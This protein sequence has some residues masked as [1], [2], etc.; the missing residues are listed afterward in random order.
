M[1]DTQQAGEQRYTLRARDTAVVLG[2]DRQRH[3]LVSLTAPGLERN[4]VREPYF[5]LNLYRI[6]HGGRL[7]AIA[8]YEPF[9]LVYATESGLKLAWQPTEANPCRLEAEYT[10]VDE[11]TVDLKLFLEA[12][13]PL[14]NYELTVSSYFDF[15][16]EPY[17]VVPSWP[18]KTAEDDLLLL[19][20]EDHPYIKGHYVYL[21]RDNSAA[22]TL[23][24][25]RW[26]D[27]KSGRPIAHFVTGPCYGV[28][29]AVMGTESLHIVQAA[30]PD[31]CR[32]IGI[33][34]SSPDESDII[35]QHNALYFTLFGGDLEP[36]DR[37]TAAIR[38]T[39]VAGPPTLASVR[40]VYES[41][42]EPG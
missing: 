33:T 32:A 41:L 39:L 21:P 17:S 27:E 15:A 30:R 26:L 36:G 4:V 28:P 2:A 5:A 3:G 37:R 25:G 19:K 18:G 23:L 6:M 10:I 12:Q 40:R 34:Y 24:D 1:T 22:H 11:A 42:T 16:L 31:E 8:R 20:L 14:S 7:A 13:Q 35:R 29:A 38:Q 9:E